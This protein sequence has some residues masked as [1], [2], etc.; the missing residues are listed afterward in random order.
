[1]T[2]FGLS[3][4][5][6]ANVYIHQHFLK[7]VVYVIIIDQWNQTAH[8]YEIQVKVIYSPVIL[9]SLWRQSAVLSSYL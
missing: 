6:L 9:L 3:V 8:L 5:S 2:T 7:V 4:Y 1:M